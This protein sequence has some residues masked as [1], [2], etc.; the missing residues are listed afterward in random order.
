VLAPHGP[1]RLSSVGFRDTPLVGAGLAEARRLLAESLEQGALGFSTGLSYYPNSYSDT[2][3]LA[4][5]NETVAA[6]G[7][8]YVVHVRN[9]NNDRAPGGTGVSEAL[10]VGRRS[11]V[12]VHVSHY[13]THPANAGQA[14]ELMEE[15]DAAKADGVDVTLETYPYAA[16]A[17]VPGYFL[18]GEFHEGGVDALLGRLA[19]RRLRPRLLH[20]MRTLFP[21]ALAGSAWTWIDHPQL[22]RF[23]G[24][25]MAEAAAAQ[26]CSVEAHVLDV[27][28]ESGLACGFRY[29]PPASVT[30][31]RQIEADIVP[32]L[33]RA[34]Y[35]VGSDGIPF[36]GGL[37]HPRAYGTFPR[38]LGR[39]RRRH[40]APLEHLVR[41]MTGLPAARFRITDRGLLREGAFADITLFNPDTIIDTASYEDPTAAPAG[42][43]CVIV[44]GRLAVE[45][46][47]GVHLVLVH[48]DGAVDELHHRLDQPRVAS[49]A[50]ERLVVGVGR[51]RG[52][53]DAARL[54]PHLLAVEGV[55]LVRGGPQQRRLRGR[56][57]QDGRPRDATRCSGSATSLV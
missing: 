2:A 20:S 23:E 15:I 30:V 47:L 41:S 22:R 48:V 25:A 14:A 4:A 51:E 34:D 49:E 54:A 10:E 38:I 55:D 44:N 8:V 18:A 9:H 42:I 39:L 32:L 17:T 16:P 28:L 11:G 45:G 33:S 35:T 5:L 26:G 43:P 12:A 7:G 27:M 1:L 50:A 40:N 3:E 37:P 53:G 57:A 24:M 36:S 13:R 56:V 46:G 6:H 31:T 29:Q 19:D 21:G 52:A